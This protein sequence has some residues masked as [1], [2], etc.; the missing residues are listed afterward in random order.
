[1][2]RK[3]HS[4]P[5]FEPQTHCPDD[6]FLG[7][8]YCH[9]SRC[10]TLRHKVRPPGFWSLTCTCLSTIHYDDCSQRQDHVR[11]TDYCHESESEEGWSYPLRLHQVVNDKHYQ[12]ASLLTQIKSHA[13]EGEAN[14]SDGI[15]F[16]AVFAAILARWRQETFSA[17]FFFS[18]WTGKGQRLFFFFWK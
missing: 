8:L 14:C 15:H 1:M 17:S 16:E 11:N 5:I 12:Q 10:W 3:R 2:S 4:I 9:G 13:L 6:S 18:P 7:V